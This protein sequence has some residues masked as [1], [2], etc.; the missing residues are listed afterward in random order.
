MLGGNALAD[1]DFQGSGEGRSLD[2][3][4]TKGGAKMDFKSG[5]EAAMGLDLETQDAVEDAAP[6]KARK[7]SEK[8][9]AMDAK[10]KGSE[11]LVAEKAGEAMAGAMAEVAKAAADKGDS[12]KVLDRRFDVKTDDS[13]N[14]L[15]T[16]FGKETLEDR[17]LLPGESYQ[18]LFARV[19]DYFADDAEH[20]QRL[21]D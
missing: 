8:A 12:K 6:A 1:S 9:V 2:P 16:E 3:G 19:A 15:L 10:D 14:E 4:I 21:Y 17:Y 5:D 7:S 18:D 13:R 20:A 11:E